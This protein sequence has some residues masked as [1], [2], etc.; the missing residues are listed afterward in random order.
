[1]AKVRGGTSELGV[2][3][4]EAERDVRD[5]LFDDLNAPRARAALDVFIRRANAELD[6]GGSDAG[7]LARARAAFATIDGVLDLTPRPQDADGD[8]D[9]RLER[10][11]LAA[12]V[13]ERLAARREARASRDFSRADAIRAEIEARGVEVKDGPTGTEWRLVRGG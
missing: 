5:A 9:A 10:E 1:L 12:W 11:R 7:G 6:R 8:D 13:E 2:V 4:E 3:A